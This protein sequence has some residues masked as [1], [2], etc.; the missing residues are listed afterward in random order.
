MSKPTDAK[1]AEAEAALR[2]PFRADDP[3]LEV[4]DEPRKVSLVQSVRMNADLTRRLFTEAERRGVTPS[5]LIRELV[6]AGLDET[7]QSAMVNVAD[8][9]RAIDSLSRKSA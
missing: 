5:Q 4:L 1:V 7:E 3:N 8:V 6:E 9:H 2:Q